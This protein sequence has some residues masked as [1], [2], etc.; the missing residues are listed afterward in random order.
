MINAQ[1]WLYAALCFLLHSSSNA[2]VLSSPAELTVREYDFI[3]V[4]GG[5][6]GSVVASRL[7]EDPQVA[8][9]LIEAGGSHEGLLNLEA[10]FLGVTLPNTAVDWNYTAVPQVGLN[11]RTFHYTRGYVLGGSSS[12]NLLTWNRGSNDLWDRWA[13]LTG[14]DGW[15]WNQVEKY[16]L[17]TSRLVPSADGHDT[18]GQVDPSVHGY[19]PV[20]VSVPGFELPTDSITETAS[21][22]LGG[23]FAFNVD[24]NSGN[25]VGTGYMQSTVGGGERSSAA[26]AYLP[27]LVQSRTNLDI[28]LNTRATKLVKSGSSKLGPIF[29]TVE[30]ASSPTDKRI[31]V[32]AKKEVIVSAGAF[33]TPQ[34]LLLSGIGPANDLKSVSI[35]PIVDLPDVG[36]YLLDHALLPNYFSVSTNGTWDDLLRNPAVFNATLEEWIENRQG[37]FVDS[38]GNT[39]SYLRLP[40]NSPA[41]NDTPDPASGPLSPHTEFIVVDGFAAFGPVPQPATG[42]YITILTAVVSTTSSG[43]VTLASSDPFDLPLIDP[44]LLTTSFDIEAMIQT[45]KDAQTFLQASPWQKAYRPVPFGDLA[46]ATTDELKAQYARQNT[47]TESHPSGTARMSP[48]QADWGVVDSKLRLKGAQGVRVV[49]ASVFPA[50]PE[51]HI[52]APIYVIAERASDLIKSAYGL[53]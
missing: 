39:L 16:Y 22:E 11:N 1:P 24:F 49:D 52:Q 46:T 7:S 34:L 37:L 18:I 29:Q 33:A 32:S 6:A 17:K 31:L 4:G 51:C 8:V 2:K 47:F 21:R 19:G 36:Q 43:A 42:N 48:D 53:L 23:R 3:V 9:L 14:D 20:Q 10:P 30:I 38:P 40:E 25:F 12:V 5:T 45:M 28:L 27:P 15:S 26:T 35:T 41:F 44:R 13:T 50:I